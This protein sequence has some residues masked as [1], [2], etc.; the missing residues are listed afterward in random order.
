MIAEDA[1]TRVYIP[2]YPSPFFRA[3]SRSILFALKMAPPTRRNGKS[4]SKTTKATLAPVAVSQHRVAKSRKSKAQAVKEESDVDNFTIPSRE[5]K[6]SKKWVR[7]KIKGECFLILFRHVPC[8]MAGSQGAP[9]L[10]CSECHLN[11]STKSASPDTWKSKKPL[12]RSLVVPTVAELFSVI[13]TVLASRRTNVSRG[14]NY[15]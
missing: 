1:F 3:T 10:L 4:T 12:A 13:H 14:A 15:S 2:T 8:L 9:W 6:D 5:D 11:Q 7:K